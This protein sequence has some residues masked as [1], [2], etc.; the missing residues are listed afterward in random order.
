MTDQQKTQPNSCSTLR[1]IYVVHG[2]WVLFLPGRRYE[3]LCDMCCSMVV[4]VLIFSKLVVVVDVVV[5]SFLWLR[6]SGGER[7][8]GGGASLPPP[9]FSNLLLHSD[10]PSSCSLCR[11]HFSRRSIAPQHLS[12]YCPCSLSPSNFQS[13]T[14]LPVPQMDLFN[15]CLGSE[16]RCGAHLTER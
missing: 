9:H 7:G 8:R 14:T 6:R 5:L 11:C 4:F 1:L 12:S 3:N 10:A 13:L 15:K 2:C 16:Y